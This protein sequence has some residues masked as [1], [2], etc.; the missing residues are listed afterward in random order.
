MRSANFNQLESE[1]LDLGEDTVYMRHIYAK[2]GVLRRTEA[3]ERT[4]TGT[5]CCALRPSP[6]RRRFGATLRR[7]RRR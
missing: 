2:L 5:D 1:R 6:L 4:R 7:P 3:V